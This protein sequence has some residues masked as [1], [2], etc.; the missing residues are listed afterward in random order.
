MGKV[1]FRIYYVLDIII[2]NI[3]LKIY[4]FIHNNVIF[5]NNHNYW[6]RNVVVNKNKNKNKNNLTYIF[7]QWIRWT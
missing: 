4:I 6:Y 1:I 7:K 5:F 3:F 2:I